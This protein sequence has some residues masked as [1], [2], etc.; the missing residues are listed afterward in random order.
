MPFPTVELG[1][2]AGPGAIFNHSSKGNTQG[3]TRGTLGAWSN[4]VGRA[5]VGHL[6]LGL[7]RERKKHHCKEAT[8][9]SVSV[10]AAKSI[11]NSLPSPAQPR[12]FLQYRFCVSPPTPHHSPNTFFY[13]NLGLCASF[14]SCL[15]CPSLLSTLHPQVSLKCHPVF[16]AALI[17]FPGY[18]LSTL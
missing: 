15:E 13:R 10:K 17:P 18:G 6:P 11:P 9:M 14:S 16:Q 4:L 5:H 12:Y 3:M 8:I 1:R 7:F 2:W